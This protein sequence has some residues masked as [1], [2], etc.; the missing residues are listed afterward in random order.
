MQ[1]PRCKAQSGWRSVNAHSN[2]LSIQHLL[3]WTIDFILIWL[4]R[5]LFCLIETQH[6]GKAERCNNLALFTLTRLKMMYHT[7]RFIAPAIHL[8]MNRY[9]RSTSYHSPI[10]YLWLKL[11]VKLHKAGEPLTHSVLLFLPSFVSPCFNCI[12]RHQHLFSLS[13]WIPCRPNQSGHI[14]RGAHILLLWAF[15]ILSAIVGAYIGFIIC[16]TIIFAVIWIIQVAI[17]VQPIIG[18][19]NA[20]RCAMVVA[21]DWMMV[22]SLDLADI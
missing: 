12:D 15:R 18:V 10:I 9:S 7:K 3:L 4:D 14:W 2:V 22:D 1:F 21:F 6:C 13:L 20:F 16:C 5:L 8:F 19:R 17:P 11:S